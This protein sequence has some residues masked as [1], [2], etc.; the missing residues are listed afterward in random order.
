MRMDH[1]HDVSTYQ[2]ETVMSC[3]LSYVSSYDGFI[4]KN[5]LFV[6]KRDC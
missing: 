4:P 2:I 5:D 1:A 3:N 6:V